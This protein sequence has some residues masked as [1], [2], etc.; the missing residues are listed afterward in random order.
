MINIALKRMYA[1]CFKT[2]HSFRKATRCR[3][4]LTRRKAR[5]WPG[6]ALCGA[7]GIQESPGENALGL[8]GIKHEL[9]KQGGSKGRAAFWDSFP[10]LPTC[11]QSNR[12]PG[13]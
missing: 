13:S 7:Q 5:A 4:K 9:V 12:G 8:R 10:Q 1:R 6:L 3:G 11:T 2:K